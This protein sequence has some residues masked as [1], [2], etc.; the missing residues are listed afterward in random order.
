M[1]RLKYKD[2][3]LTLQQKYPTHMR[4]AINEGYKI[5]ITFLTQHNTR[6]PYG[7]IN[8]MERGNTDTTTTQRK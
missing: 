2:F 4:V 3:I 5:S 8:K 6:S 1:D 7:R